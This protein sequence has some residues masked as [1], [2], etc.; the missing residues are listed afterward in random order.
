MEEGLKKGWIRQPPK[1]L[2]DLLG[3]FVFVER[4]PINT[5]E[6]KRNLTAVFSADRPDLRGIRP[7]YRHSGGG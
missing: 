2:I 7:S 1:V 3:V 6:F 4:N 5:E